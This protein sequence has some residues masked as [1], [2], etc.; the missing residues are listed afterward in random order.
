MNFP[1]NT[2]LLHSTTMQV[3][4]KGGS[5]NCQIQVFP[6][7]QLENQV[8]TYPLLSALIFDILQFEILIEFDELDFFPSLY[9]IFAGY[10]GSKN[11][12]HLT[13]YFKLDNVKNQVQIDRRMGNLICWKLYNRQIRYFAV[14]PLFILAGYLLPV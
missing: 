5:W 10:T 11:P 14:A 8:H 12:V 9:W 7:F 1:L 13:R 4:K 2:F 6:T 3:L